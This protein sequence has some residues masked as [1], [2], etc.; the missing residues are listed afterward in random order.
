ME[1]EE[2]TST[3]YMGRK[4]FGKFE[5]IPHNGTTLIDVDN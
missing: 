3:W 1:F 5:N 4:K 2:Q